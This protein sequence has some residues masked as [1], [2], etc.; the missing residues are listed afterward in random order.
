MSRFILT[1]D[2]RLQNECP[3]H[4]L[5]GSRTVRI[6]WKDVSTAKKLDMVCSGTVK[7]EMRPQ[8]ALGVTHLCFALIKELHGRL[9]TAGQPF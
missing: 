6:D 3:L 9:L 8:R 2:G 1:A 5:A 4:D 7:S